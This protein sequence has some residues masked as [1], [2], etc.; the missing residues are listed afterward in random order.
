M[1]INDYL[2]QVK[3]RKNELVTK[4]GQLKLKAAD[5]IIISLNITEDPIYY[6]NSFKKIIGKVKILIR[7]PLSQ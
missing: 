7:L 4:C 1:P 5:W 2:K 3:K 6:I